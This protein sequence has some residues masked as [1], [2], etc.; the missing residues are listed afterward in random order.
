MYSC[1]SSRPRHLSV[2][3]DKFKYKNYYAKL[4]GGVLNFK[5]RHYILANGYSNEYWVI[6]G[7]NFTS[8]QI[9]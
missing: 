7:K 2:A 3:I 8:K 1:P 9:N 4:I 6:M 5:T